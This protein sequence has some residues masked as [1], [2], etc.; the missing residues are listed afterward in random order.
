MKKL[1]TF[2]L[3]ALLGLLAL[4][5]CEDKD[6]G[7]AQKA[8]EKIDNTY[9]NVKASLHNNLTEGPAEKVG[10]KIDETTNPNKN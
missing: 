4:T 2:G 9:E 1:L 6:K 5:A 7:N 10:K 8:G 3:V